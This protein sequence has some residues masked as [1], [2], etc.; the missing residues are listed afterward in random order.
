[1]GYQGAKAGLTVSTAA[2][3]NSIGTVP[4]NHNR[5]PPLGRSVLL[6]LSARHYGLSTT[7]PTLRA[8]VLPGSLAISGS[9]LALALVLAHGCIWGG[10][11]DDGEARIL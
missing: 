9:M 2:A 6:G 11:L 1:M 5:L 4:R 10:A 8:R 7:S 3:P